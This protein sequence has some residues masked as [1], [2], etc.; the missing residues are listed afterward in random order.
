MNGPQH[1]ARTCAAE[2]EEVGEEVE[3]DVIARVKGAVALG[4]E[5]SGERPGE[6]EEGLWMSLIA[7]T[8]WRGAEAGEGEDER[9]RL[10]MGRTSLR[11]MI[12]RGL[13]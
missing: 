10:L 6:G 7:G 4:E 11:R 3:G 8:I 9:R 1:G 12:R 2:H 5:E 13:G